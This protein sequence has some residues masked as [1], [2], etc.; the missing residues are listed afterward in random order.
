M[1]LVSDDAKIRRHN[2]TGDTSTITI[3][4]KV[5]AVDVEASTVTIEHPATQQDSDLS[6]LAT[7]VVRLP[8]KS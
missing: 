2:P 7:G 4:A 1:P 6:A 3:T 5:T 8:S